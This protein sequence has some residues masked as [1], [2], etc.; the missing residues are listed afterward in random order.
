MLDG[1]IVMCPRHGSKFDVT[2]GKVVGGP[3]AKDEPVYEVRIDGT[4]IK[5]NI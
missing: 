4:S 5:V 1:K 3:A 2:T